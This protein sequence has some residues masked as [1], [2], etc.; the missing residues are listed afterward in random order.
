ML[1]SLKVVSVTL[2]FSLV[3]SIRLK[4]FL[5][6]DSLKKQSHVVRVYVR[7]PNETENHECEKNT[8][9]QIPDSSFFISMRI[10]LRNPEIGG[11][12]NQRDRSSRKQLQATVPYVRTR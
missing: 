2:T 1:K 6:H 9:F 7:R 3:N 11:T 5:R 4:K 10:H 12:Q 8:I